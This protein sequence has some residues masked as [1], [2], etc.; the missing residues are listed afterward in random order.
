MNTIKGW[1][2]AD[3]KYIHFPGAA[4]TASLPCLSPHLHLT[5]PWALGLGAQGWKKR[6]KKPKGVNRNTPSCQ[7]PGLLEQ[8]KQGLAWVVLKISSPKRSDLRDL[9]CPIPGL[10]DLHGSKNHPELCLYRRP[11]WLPIDPSVQEDQCIGVLHKYPGASCRWGRSENLQPGIN[12][13][14]PLQMG[15]LRPRKDEFL[16]QDHVTQV[17]QSLKLEA[18]E[19]RV[20]FFRRGIWCICSF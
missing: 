19:L 7:G 13:S 17:S 10:P 5:F 6:G 3:S 15:R 11:I 18:L 14:F 16:V 9:L 12:H 2:W 8:E 4:T 20:S 1:H